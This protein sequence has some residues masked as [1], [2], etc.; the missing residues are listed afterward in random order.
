[1][2]YQMC[3]VGQDSPSPQCLC[4]L[5]TK[6]YEISV[7]GMYFTS[8][9]AFWPWAGWGRKKKGHEKDF[10]TP[11]LTKNSTLPIKAFLKHK[12]VPLAQ[13]TVKIHEAYSFMMKWGKAPPGADSQVPTEQVVNA[14][15]ADRTNHVSGGR[16]CWIQ[17]PSL[18]IWNNCSLDCRLDN[19]DARLKFWQAG[20]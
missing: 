9:L 19:C 17:P 11:S 2:L 20:I 1:M 8:L 15:C 14:P 16:R 10:P 4:A 5:E 12:S 18:H 6:E 3:P 7:V 13:T